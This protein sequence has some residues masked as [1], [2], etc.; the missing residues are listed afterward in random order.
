MQVVKRDMQIRSITSGDADCIGHAFLTLKGCIY[1]LDNAIS[2]NNLNAILRRRKQLY[3]SVQ[4]YKNA[5]KRN[6]DISIYSLK[7]FSLGDELLTIAYNLLQISSL[8]L[9]SSVV[10]L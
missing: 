2:L 6:T 9:L 8:S 10:L 3:E 5:K 1:K 7:I 4:A